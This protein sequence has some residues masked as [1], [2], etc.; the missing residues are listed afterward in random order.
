[1][2]GTYAVVSCRA[3]VLAVTH[4]KINDVLA[5]FA[6]AVGLRT[7]TRTGSA[8][9]ASGAGRTSKAGV[10]EGIITLTKQ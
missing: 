10:E 3:D 7:T 8:G 2:T 4:V 5:S 1:M 6:P 9:G